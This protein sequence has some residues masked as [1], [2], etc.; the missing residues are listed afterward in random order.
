MQSLLTICM[1]WRDRFEAMALLNLWPINTH[2]PLPGIFHSLVVSVFVISPFPFYWYLWTSPKKWL[3]ICEGSDPSHRMAQVA[4]LFKAMQIL[5]LLT[6]TTFSVPPIICM[7]LF[8]F[9]Q[10]LNYR[11]MSPI[12]TLEDLT[13]FQ[14]LNVSYYVLL[15]TYCSKHGHFSVCWR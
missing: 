6:V 15:V 2:L 3:K 4:H 12:S 8:A 5:G 9:G 13:E 7:A 10:F 1:Q 14:L 11:Y